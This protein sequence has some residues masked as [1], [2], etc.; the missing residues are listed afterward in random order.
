MTGEVSFVQLAMSAVYE[1]VRKMRGPGA[2]MRRIETFEN[3]VC[4][5]SGVWMRVHDLAEERLVQAFKGQLKG[6]ALD[7]K[8]VFDRI[9]RRYNSLCDDTEVRKEDKAADE[10]LRA[11]LQKNLIKAK[12][13]LDGPIADAVSA[14]KNYSAA[15]DGVSSSMT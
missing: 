13:L 6:L 8:E 14:C 9:H 4:K 7:V 1:D 12:E 10:E 5:S 3:R 15:K 11:K 2:P